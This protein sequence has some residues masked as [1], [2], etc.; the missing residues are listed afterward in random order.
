MLLKPSNMTYTYDNSEHRNDNGKVNYV[1]NYKMLQQIAFHGVVCC[2][3]KCQIVIHCGMLDSSPTCHKHNCL[4]CVR[5]EVLSLIP[6]C[7]AFLVVYIFR[8]RPNGLDWTEG[9]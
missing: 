2:L 1:A 6:H 3:H 7:S 8:T 5:Q 4:I 9:I